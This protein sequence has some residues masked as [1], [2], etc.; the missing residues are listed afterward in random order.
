MIGLVG[1]YNNSGLGIIDRFLVKNLGIPAQLLV[2]HPVKGVNID[3]AAKDY[4]MSGYRPS[5]AN[6]E[7]FLGKGIDV[8]LVVE[9]PYS[10]D[11][12]KM[13]KGRGIKVAFMPMLDSVGCE[14][15]RGWQDYVDCLI[16]P[17][18]AAYDILKDKGFR[19]CEY[20]HMPVDTEFFSFVGREFEDQA[21]F[22]FNAGYDQDGRKGSDRVL[23]LWKDLKFNLK[24]RSQGRILSDR[25]TLE[26]DFGEPELEGMYDEGD[27]YLAMSR[28]EGVGLPI[29]EAMSC[30]LPVIGSNLDVWDGVL[31]EGLTAKSDTEAAKLI[32]DLRYRPYKVRRLAVEARRRM[33]D[34]YSWDVW[35]SQYL[36]V[37]ESL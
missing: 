10:W 26:I 28:K 32:Q 1:T 16:A 36:K 17:T 7:E 31:F 35:R 34:L 22:L 20:L 24:M 5:P 18:P 29:Y 25:G 14:V 9:T 19:R 12:L 4:V 37:L 3:W 15:L 2:Q 8:L 23:R 11:L 6:C 30:G 33:E 21:V 27:I 13:A